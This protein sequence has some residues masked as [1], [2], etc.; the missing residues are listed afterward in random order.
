MQQDIGNQSRSSR[1]ASSA[2][3]RDISSKAKSD[4]WSDV[5]DPN[6]RRKIQNKLAQRRFRKFPSMLQG[7]DVCGEIPYTYP[8]IEKEDYAGRAKYCSGC[9]GR[10]C[11]VGLIF[12][13]IG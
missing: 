1:E 7:V 13:A 2:P 4:E 5:Q 12:S 8:E 9:Q 11:K 6:E 3:G 10:F